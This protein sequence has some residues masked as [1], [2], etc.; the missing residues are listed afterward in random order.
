LFQGEI[1]IPADKQVNMVWH[2]YIPPEAN[3]AQL[4][5]SSKTNQRVMHTIISE[6]LLTLM[7]VERHEVQ[8]R[9]VALKYP[10]ETS[11]PVRHERQRR[12]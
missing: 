8:W 3:S 4:T 2:N 1:Q 6:K 11:R 12:L 5:V 7:R 10:V 9:I